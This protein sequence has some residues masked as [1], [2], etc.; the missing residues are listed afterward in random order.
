MF[1]GSYDRFL[2]ILDDPQMRAEL[3]RAHTHEDLRHSTAWD[4]VRAAS[5]PFHDALIG[6][7]LKDDDELKKL[8][9]EYG[10]F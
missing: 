8:T 4:E 7:F 1:F 3:A 10:V 5:R 9:V 2:G 6:S